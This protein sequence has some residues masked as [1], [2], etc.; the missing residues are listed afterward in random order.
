[1]KR[2]AF[3]VDKRKELINFKEEKAR[4]EKK[5]RLSI[6]SKEKELSVS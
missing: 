2:I 6:E 1:M 5:K 4:L 3:I